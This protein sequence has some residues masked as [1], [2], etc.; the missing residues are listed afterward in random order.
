ML[1]RAEIAPGA[2]HAAIT[3]TAVTV[4]S[5]V[6]LSL[7]VSTRAKVQNR[8]GW[9]DGLAITAYV[10]TVPLAITIWKRKCHVGGCPH[11]GC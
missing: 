11:N 3:S 10:F 6:F 8:L 4:L 2:L 9:D 5:F 7:K 1:S